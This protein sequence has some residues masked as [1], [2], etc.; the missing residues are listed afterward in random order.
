LWTQDDQTNHGGAALPTKGL[1]SISMRNST[2]GWAVGDEGTMLHFSDGHWVA[3]TVT[4]NDLTAVSIAPNG[5]GIAV[6]K[7]GVI[8]SYDGAGWN[9]DPAAAVNLTAIKAFSNAKGWGTGEEGKI[10][11]KFGG[12]WVNQGDAGTVVPSAVGTTHLRGID[13]L[14]QQ[15]SVTDWR[16]NQ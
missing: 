8:L 14:P 7:N 15:S 9:V 13:M 6:G 1:N 2:E 11:R 12:N 3:S 16:E 10:I 4:G 5:K